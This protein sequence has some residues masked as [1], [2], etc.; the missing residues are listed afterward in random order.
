MKDI[1]IKFLIT[2]AVGSVGGLSLLWLLCYLR[3]K[4]QMR[5]RYLACCALLYALLFTFATSWLSS[6]HEAGATFSM[7]ISCSFFYLLNELN[8]GKWKF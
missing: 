3:I 6:A 5:V 7:M 4:R 1:L 8:H 2:F